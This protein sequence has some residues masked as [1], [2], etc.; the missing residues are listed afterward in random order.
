MGPAL[1]G[2]ENWGPA[3]K[4]PGYLRQD[5]WQDLS[6]LKRCVFFAALGA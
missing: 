2:G 5:E 1:G 6:R 3:P 4:P